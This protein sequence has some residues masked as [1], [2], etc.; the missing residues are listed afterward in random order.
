MLLTAGMLFLFLA[1]RARLF[2]AS[3]KHGAG[4]GGRPSWMGGYA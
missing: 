3:V 4:T 2:G 1:L